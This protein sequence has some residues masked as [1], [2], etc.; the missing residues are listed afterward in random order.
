MGKPTLYFLCLVCLL[1][2]GMTVTKI[3]VPDGAEWRIRGA[4]RM[5][6]DSGLRAGQFL[7]G[8]SAAAVL[9]RIGKRWRGER[10][11]VC[12]FRT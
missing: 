3:W 1:Y 8:V 2:C 5:C 12:G 6:C 11:R 7:T 4:C 9:F 10:V